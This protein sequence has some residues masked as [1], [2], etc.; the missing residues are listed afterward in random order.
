MISAEGSG[1]S[2]EK[3]IESALFEL[4]ARRE[5]VD[6]KIL[7]EGGLFKKARVVV[8]ISEDSRD[9]YKIKKKE[10]VT[11]TEEKL[12]VK[13][14]FAGLD[15]KLTE[16]KNKKTI[17]E[18]KEEL[19]K[20]PKDKNDK[21]ELI[22]KKIAKKESLNKKDLISVKDF[23]KG[24]LNEVNIDG[25]VFVEETAENINILI[26]GG[27]SG[28]LIGYRGECLNAIQHIAS[29]IENNSESKKRVVI[30]IEKYR[31]RRE[32]SLKGLAN[33][34]AKKVE[35]TNRSIKLEPMNANERRIIHSELHKSSLVTTTSK[36]TEPN[37]FIIVFPKKEESSDETE[38]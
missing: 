6:I 25:D 19:R 21:E 11:E 37:R 18:K 35:R 27:N 36:G 12:D 5:D 10:V 28:N 20:E 17:K 34:I 29:V 22:E 3:A 23:I 7:E 2:I 38:I 8:T 30:D 13:A 4:K 26:E 33:R 16:E 32:E 31:S 24:F 15:N 1:R 14:M 9:K